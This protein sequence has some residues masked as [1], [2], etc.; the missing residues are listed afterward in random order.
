MVR[1]LGTTGSRR[2]RRFQLAAIFSVTALLA[3]FAALPAQAVHDDNL[4]ELGGVQAA[5]ILGDNNAANGPDWGR[6]GQAGDDGIFDASGS[7]VGLPADGVASAFIA[8]ETSQAGGVDRTTFSGAGG[9]NK[10]N[11][12][13]SDEDAG[14]PDSDTWHWDSGNVPAKDDLT[15]VYAYATF[16]AANDLIF[17]AG[18]ERLAPEGDSHIDIEFFQDTVGLDEVVPCND[19][20]PDLTPCHFEGTRTVNDIIVSMDYVQ[21]GGIGEV[22]IRQ[23]NGTEYVLAGSAQ[24]EGCNVADTICAFNNGGNIDGGPW[25]NLDRH[26]AEITQLPQNAFTEFGV[27][28]TQEVGGDPCI[29]TI[30]GKTRSSQSF[31]AELKDF[32]GPTSFPICGANI[33]IAPD[34]VNEVGEEHTFTVT[35]NKELGATETPAPDGTIVTVTLTGDA[36]N[37]VDNCA[38]PGTV[39]GTCSVT[40]S[41]NT[42]GTVT[43]HAAAD[44][45]VG[46]QNIHVET[47]GTG[48]N[49]SDAVKR[50]VDAFITINPD[51]VNSIGESHTFTVTVQQNKGDG[52]GFVDAPDGTTV[53]VTL[54]DDAGAIS[55]VSSDT[56]ASPGTSSGTCSITFTSQTE[57][58]VTGTATVTFDIVTPQ[59][60]EEVTRSTDGT[61][62]NSSGA[63]KEF[64]AGSLRWS[65]VDNAGTLQGGAT[66]EVCRTHDRAGTDIP[67]E[68]QTVVDDVDVNGATTLDE[69]PDPGEFLLTGL[70]LGRYTVD[71]TVAPPGFEPDPKVETRELTLA[72]PDV[73]IPFGQAFANQRPILKL[74]EFGYTNEPTETP[75]AG[76]VS[77]TTT[78]TVKLKNF[79]G[80]S[81]SLSG[82]LAASAA[83][84]GG[85]TFGCTGGDTLAI[86]GTLAPN[87]AQTFTLTCTYNN[88][89]D[90]AVVTANLSEVDYT[91]NNLTRTASGTPASISFTIQSD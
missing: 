47:D 80:A 10:N 35:V 59:G 60:T 62:Q 37:V 65:K 53:N 9:S 64:V 7:P 78:Y 55:T 40:F 6:T 69:D 82:T 73:E 34:D 72:N 5:D 75:T 20:G 17:Y 56:C 48:N 23:W 87:G 50:F 14:A 24:G 57:G 52:A 88:A 90:G 8:D 51:D 41:S 66:F 38:S 71:E 18:F 4:F 46:G 19:P 3:A 15:N 81:V 44:V 49:S 76:V 86:S 84:L 30:M 89:A 22:S 58:T 2:R 39:G 21:G 42:P 61:G 70:A 45:L 68:C 91:L 85:G 26:G 25:V 11:D 29:T 83:G 16:N 67:D 31:T 77:G 1:I 13:I 54:T 63:V 27:N 32:A 43:G 79:G 33:S 74:T 28:I 36:D 12:A